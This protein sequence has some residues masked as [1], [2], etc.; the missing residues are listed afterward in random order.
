MRMY[1]WCTCT[2]GKPFCSRLAHSLWAFSPLLSQAGAMQMHR[3][4]CDSWTASCIALSPR[5]QS[6]PEYYIHY[7]IQH[8]TILYY[9]M[10]YYHILYYTITYIYIYIHVCIYICI[11]IYIYIYKH[12]VHLRCVG[13]RGETERG[14]GEE[15][16]YINI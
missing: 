9:A 16:V 15:G 1:M 8:N 14:A 6:G 10:L 4:R 5:A 12:V 7:T 13:R 11:Y 2:S 3:S